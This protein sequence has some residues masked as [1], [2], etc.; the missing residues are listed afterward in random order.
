MRYSPTATATFEEGYGRLKEL[1]EF[2]PEDRHLV[3]EDL[4]NFNVLVDRDRI[5]AVLDWG[6]SIYGDFLYDLVKI[7]FYEPWYPQSTADT[8]QRAQALFAQA[9]DKHL[10]LLRGDARDLYDQALVLW[11]NPDIQW[12]LALVLEDLGQ[13][14]RAY[15]QLD[16]LG[17]ALEGRR[18]VEA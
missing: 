3:H 9:I 1:V 4:M 18:E 12:N 15:Q 11:D 16:T 5:S 17:R 2:C 6:S 14:L 8:R 13:Y 7:V 10:Q